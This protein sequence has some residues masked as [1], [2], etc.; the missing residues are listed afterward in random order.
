VDSELIS[1]ILPTY[2]EKD[3][4]VPL[5][6]AI[7]GA[8]K[9]RPHEIIIVDDQSPDGTYQALCALKDDRLKIILRTSEPSLARSIRCGLEK[10]RGEVFLV[11]DSDFDHDPKYI[12]FMVNMVSHYDFV[13]GS[14]FVYG[15]KMQGW[16]RALCSWLFNIFIRLAT[17]SRLSDHLY[18]Y[19]AIKRKAL[20]RCPYNKIFYGYGDY[21]IRLLYYLQKYQVS[22]LQFPAVNGGRV[23]SKGF[24]FL[25]IF[26]QYFLAVLRLPQMVESHV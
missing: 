12:P 11:M 18:G 14:R 2:N 6:R 25:R 21:Y 5:I 26:W 22:I 17:G 8:L 10:A 13:C 24:N 3:H 4:I 9:D 23:R 16:W 19:F 1:V 7:H 15:G 20:E